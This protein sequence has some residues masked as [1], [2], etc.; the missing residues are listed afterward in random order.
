[1]IMEG[2]LVERGSIVEAAA[3][4]HPG[5]RV[6]A[7]EVWGGNPAVFKRKVSKEEAASVEGHAQETSELAAEHAHEF[8]PYST[9]YTQAERLGLEKTQKHVAAIVAKH[10]QKQQLQ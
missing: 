10:E 9:A 5:R 7:G 4:V 3:V 6:P 8:L 2:A 1:M